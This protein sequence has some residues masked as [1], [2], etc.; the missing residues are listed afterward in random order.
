MH[1]SEIYNWAMQLEVKL[2]QW[3]EQI[4]FFLALHSWIIPLF[5][6]MPSIELLLR[7]MWGHLMLRRVSNPWNM[8]GPTW[9]PGKGGKQQATEANW[10]LSPRVKG[11]FTGQG[12]RC[13]TTRMQPRARCPGLPLIYPIKLLIQS[14]ERLQWW[15][16]IPSK[17]Y[18]KLFCVFAFS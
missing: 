3:K 2:F 12:W 4:S 13:R 8:A 7:W 9:H 17:L 15:P 10:A 16:R 14:I 11:P 1:S 6:L 18:T 5:P